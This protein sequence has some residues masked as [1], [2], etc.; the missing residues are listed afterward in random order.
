MDAAVDPE[1]LRPEA[2]LVVQ[3]LCRS[4]GEPGSRRFCVSCGADQRPAVTGPDIVRIERQPPRA[5]M[6]AIPELRRGSTSA[7]RALHWVGVHGGAGESTLAEFVPG[8]VE[9]FGAWPTELP[10]GMKRDQPTPVI[11][12]TRSTVRGLLGA[13]R[14]IAT[15]V[16]GRVP[17][18]HLLGLVVIA[19]IPGRKPRELRDLERLVRGGVPRSW[20]ID[21]DPQLRLVEKPADLHAAPLDLVRLRRDIDV[22]FTH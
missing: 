3:G 21:F 9:G 20:L 19:D 7:P 18:I 8:T 16:A 14:A 2:E 13:K 17:Q 22:L 6:G 15:S 10:A 5:P 12:V 11:L 4:C 1:R